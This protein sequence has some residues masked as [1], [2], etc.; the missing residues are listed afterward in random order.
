MRSFDGMNIRSQPLP[1]RPDPDA[2]ATAMTTE[3]RDRAL[4]ELQ[5]AS[6]I[7]PAGFNDP[8][9][10]PAYRLLKFPPGEEGERLKALFDRR[11]RDAMGPIGPAVRTRQG[12]QVQGLSLGVSMGTPAQLQ[13]RLKSAGQCA[14]F[15]DQPRTRRWRDGA[16]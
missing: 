12:E 1:L 3:E 7:A 16:I 14:E 11:N 6:V 15:P 2:V 10:N 5:S 13:Q 8:N 9:G 4:T